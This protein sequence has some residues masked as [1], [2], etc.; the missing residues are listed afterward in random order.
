[1]YPSVLLLR[2]STLLLSASLYPS[3][4]PFFYFCLVPPKL[5]QGHHLFLVSSCILPYFLNYAILPCSSSPFCCY[6]PYSTIRYQVSITAANL[7]FVV[8]GTN[9]CRFN[10]IMSLLVLSGCIPSSALNTVVLVVQENH[11]IFSS[12]CPLYLASN[13]FTN[14]EFLSH[15]SPA[16]DLR[17]SRSLPILL[18]RLFC[19]H[20]FPYFSCIY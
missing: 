13:C 14:F 5:L 6:A 1:M 10:S 9:N 17:T 12:C 8:F 16:T 3:F 19:E 4:C 7:F 18:Q 11:G 15:A 20:P 2:D